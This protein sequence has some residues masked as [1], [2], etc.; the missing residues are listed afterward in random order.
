MAEA[1]EEW[2]IVKREPGNVL[3]FII[4]NSG[5]I[6]KLPEEA[7]PGSSAYTA[8]MSYMANKDLDGEWKPIGG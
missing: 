8:T 7:A 4:K 2:R 5:V 3:T 1:E 6:A